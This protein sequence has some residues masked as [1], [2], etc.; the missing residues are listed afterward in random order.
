MAE[1]PSP[2]VPRPVLQGGRR[3]SRAPRLIAIVAILAAPAGVA[4]A[5]LLSFADGEGGGAPSLP[6]AVGIA[7]G[8][9]RP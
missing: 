3:R 4:A 9:H 5:A 1:R 7:A 8:G 2:P 6:L